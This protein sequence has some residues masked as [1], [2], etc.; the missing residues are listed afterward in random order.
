[1]DTNVFKFRFENCN[2]RVSNFFFF[3]CAIIKKER[4]KKL[5]IL[6]EGM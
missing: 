5:M 1:M 3:I 6:F 4:K 2:L